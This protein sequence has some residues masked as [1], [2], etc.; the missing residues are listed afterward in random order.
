M[1]YAGMGNSFRYPYAKNI[2]IERGL[3]RVIEKIKRVQFFAQQGINQYNFVYFYL[4]LCFDAVCW[5]TG[6]S[7][8]LFKDLVL[9]MTKGDHSGPGLT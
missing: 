1:M 2:N 5:V 3:T 7:S 9:A 4:F 6:L 8:D